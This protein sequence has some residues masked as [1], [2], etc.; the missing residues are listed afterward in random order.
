MIDFWVR[1][2]IQLNRPQKREEVGMGSE[3]K[4]PECE[5]TMMLLPG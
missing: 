4:C 3:K 2:R 1:K 5:G